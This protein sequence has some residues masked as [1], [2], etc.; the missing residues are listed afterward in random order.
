[1]VRDSHC[2]A[3]WREER[4][5]RRVWVLEHDPRQMTGDQWQAQFAVLNRVAAHFNDVTE[6]ELEAELDAALVGGPF[7]GPS[8][9]SG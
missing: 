6:E 9:S 2:F 8:T 1:M 7:N 4:V 3:A 5:T